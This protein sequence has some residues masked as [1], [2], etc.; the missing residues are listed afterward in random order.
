MLQH[1]NIGEI[2]ILQLPCPQRHAFISPDPTRAFFC[3]NASL[4]V[5]YVAARVFTCFLRMSLIT[6]GSECGTAS[7][8]DTTGIRGFF[9]SI[10]S[11]TAPS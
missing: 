2:S 10:E 6:A 11:S 1:G 3:Q 4:C 9:T 7:T 8:F 5:V